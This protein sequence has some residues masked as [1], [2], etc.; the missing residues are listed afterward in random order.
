[1]LNSS[2]RAFLAAPSAAALVPSSVV[3][4]S[5]EPDPILAAI[6]NH[7]KLYGSLGQALTEQSALEEA[8]NW[9]HTA[10]KY[11]SNPRWIAIENRVGELHELINLAE[12]E[13][14]NVAPTTSKGVIEL[15][16]YVIAQEA[17]GNEWRGHYTDDDRP[18][19]YR[20][21]YYYLLRNVLSV[22]DGQA[23]QS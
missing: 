13:L 21:W 10:G 2:R 23:V 9:L 14:I 5:I 4:A 7:Q 6:R 17:K 22:L 12:C 1:M 20:S 8:L 15:F 18:G 19:S 16:R 3:A 11:K